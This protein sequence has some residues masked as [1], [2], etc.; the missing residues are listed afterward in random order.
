MV[1][2]PTTRAGGPS[3]ESTDTSASSRRW[4]RSWRALRWRASTSSRANHVADD[5]QWERVEEYRRIAPEYEAIAAAQARLECEG[6]FEGRG[7][8][9]PGLFDWITHEALAEFER[10]H[11]VYGWG[12]IGGDT[13]AV[14]Q[15]TPEE[16]EQEAV[17]RVLTERAMHAAQVIEDGSTST[18]RNGEPRTY[19]TEDGERRNRFQTS[20]PSFE[21]ASSKRSGSRPRSL[22]TPGCSRSATSL[23]TA[24]SR[25]EASSFRPT[26]DDS[27]DL[28][29]EID[30]GRRVVRVPLR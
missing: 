8:Y 7:E 28:L 9:T 29:V 3:A 12:F 10:R 5:E 26:T 4:R 14:L 21:N 18:K 20:K 25:F 2:S 11:R 30:R 23:R 1:S 16:T 13:L 27:M 6:F 19:R 24:S 17:I 15:K 22:R